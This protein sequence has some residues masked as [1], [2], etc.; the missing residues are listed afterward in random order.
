MQR[1]TRAL[2]RTGGW[3]FGSGVLSVVLLFTVLGGATRQGPH[4]NGG[5]LVLIIALGCL[6]T[7]L[8]TLA[9]GFS[10]LIGERTRQG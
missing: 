7:G 10:K 8:L 4:T 2:L 3:I 6:P 5:W 1:D 9:L